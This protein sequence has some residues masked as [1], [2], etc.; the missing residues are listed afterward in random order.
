M[1]HYDT[2]IRYYFPII[3][4]IMTHGIIIFLIIFPI[5]THYLSLSFLLFSIMTGFLPPKNGNV[6]TA[7]LDPYTEE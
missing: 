3:V 2:I 5:M 1:T 4:P 6:K 7:N